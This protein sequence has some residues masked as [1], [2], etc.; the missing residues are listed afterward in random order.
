MDNS[1]IVLSALAEPLH[2][3]EILEDL[4]CCLIEGLPGNCDLRGSDAYWSY[5]ARISVDLCLHDIDTQRID[6]TIVVGDPDL[7]RPSTRAVTVEIPLTS[8]EESRERTGISAPSMEIAVDGAPLSEKKKQ[9]YY[10]PRRRA[11]K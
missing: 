7:S 1:Q 6:K 3:V 9:R 4:A 2:G 11:N 8:A 5:S 10:T